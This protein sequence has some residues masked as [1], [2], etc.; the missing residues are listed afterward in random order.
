ME[1]SLHMHDWLNLWPLVIELDL[2]APFYHQ[3][4]GGKAK[5][6]NPQ[7]MAQSFW[8][9]APILEL[10]RG[11]AK[12]YLIRIN[13]GMVERIVK[14]NKKCSYH[15]CCSGNFKRFKEL[16]ANI[17]DRNQIHISCYNIAT[18]SWI[19][20]SCLICSLCSF[21]CLLWG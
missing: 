21:V 4:S 17:W 5:K 19:L 13:L 18:Y 8:P 6:P 9:S 7:I 3:R 1:V 2:Q 11:P 20:L 10:S 14:S 16:C 12:R 15:S